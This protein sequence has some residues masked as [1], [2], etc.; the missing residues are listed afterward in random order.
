MFR[1]SIIK[2]HASQRKLQVICIMSTFH[3]QTVILGGWVSSV[4][5]KSGLTKQCKPTSARLKTPQVS[6]QDSALSTLS[7]DEL[8]RNK[9]LLQCTAC[10]SL[11]DSRNKLFRTVHCRQNCP[12]ASED[13]T[14]A[15]HF[16][17]LYSELVLSPFEQL[18]RSVCD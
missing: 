3:Q 10:H 4:H 11:H 9:T 16:T 5:F 7:G 12:Q 6:T 13:W 2:G 8:P 17:L 14:H 1:W 15:R 18:C